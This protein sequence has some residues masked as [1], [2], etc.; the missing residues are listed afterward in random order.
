MC[1]SSRRRL[2]DA[3]VIPAAALLPA[4]EGG[5]QVMVVGT[6]SVAHAEARS[7]SGVREADKVQV[8][9]GLQA[10]E[11]VITVGGVGLDDGAKVLVGRAKA[12]EKDDE[13]DAK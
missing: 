7:R 9:N 10:G 5:T 1:R 12:P 8:V 6:D 4:E 11:Q 2:K 3:L 13:K